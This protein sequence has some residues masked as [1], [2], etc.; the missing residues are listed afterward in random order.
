MT[1]KALARM[2][3]AYHELTEEQREGRDYLP[4]L[5]EVLWV[6]G[7]GTARTVAAPADKPDGVTGWRYF[8]PNS[9]NSR[10]RQM[11]ATWKRLAQIGYQPT[12]RENYRATLARIEMGVCYA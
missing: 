9:R 6:D 1:P 2:P 3:Q 8:P 4:E 10:A 5:P 11:L 12:S 7:N